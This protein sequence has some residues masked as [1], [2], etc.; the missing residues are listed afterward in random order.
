MDNV[1]LTEKGYKAL[2]AGLLREAISLKA[3]KKKRKDQGF[4]SPQTVNW[5]RFVS[6]SG[7]GKS[8]LKATKK[9]ASAS[10]HTPYHRKSR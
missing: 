8:S 1:H 10:C 5:N 4:S 6:Q 9:P 3:P 2:D 7:I